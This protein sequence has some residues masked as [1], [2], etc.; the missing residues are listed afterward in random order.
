MDFVADV[1]IP[2]HP[3]HQDKAQSAIASAHAQTLPVRVIPQIDAALDGAAA[4]R[5]AGVKRGN[6][7]FLIFLDADDVLTPDFVAKTL[8]KW[9]EHGCGYV[10]TDWWRGDKIAGADERNDMFDTGMYHV[11]T[12]LLPR[13]AFEYVGGFDTTVPTLE[14]EDLYR[15][16]QKIG[17]C[18]WRVAEPLM[19]YRAE[20]GQSSK[21]R[22]A[23]LSDV[24][25]NFNAR[26]GH[27]RGKR[28]CVTGNCGGTGSA[29]ALP[30]S[31]GSI[32]GPYHEGDVLAMALYTPGR[33]NSPTQPGRTYP[34]PM[35]GYPI[36]VSPNDI[37]ARP[38]MW[39]PVA[40]PEDLN[41]DVDTVLRLAGV[42]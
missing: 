8:A 19:A 9:L 33:R 40:K 11:I 36:H 20:L 3:I 30:P 25:A 15:R 27:L 18:A 39:Q 10:Y 16:L 1:I 6:S 38:D 28:M 29:P 41:P 17:L 7:I 22:D 23:L 13:K 37:I 32:Y 12:T 35:M 4:T 24:T 21:T 5:N 34:A 42:S 31:D 14:D 2:I 26:D